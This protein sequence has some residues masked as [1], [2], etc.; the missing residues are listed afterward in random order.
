MANE[1]LNLL[2][3]S[4]RI[5][6]SGNTAVIAEVLNKI[7]PMIESGPWVEANDTWAHRMTKRF[8][9]PTPSWRALNAGV[10]RTA[11]KSTQVTEPIGILEDY[12]EA[13][14]DLI[15]TSPDPAAQ[16]WLE[17]KA[18]IEGM[19]Q[20]L[21]STFL[22]GNHGSDPEEFNGLA[23]RLDST[24][25]D[26][27]VSAGGTGSTLTSVYVVQW[28][29]DRVHWLYPRNNKTA[30]IEHKDM[31]EVTILD[32][33]DSTKQFQAYRDH[34]KVNA[35]LA[36]HDDRCIARL[37]NIT[38]ASTGSDFDEDDLIEL[39]DNMP[40]EGEGCEVYVPQYVMTRMRIQVKD[41]A[42]YLL[43]F[44]EAMGGRKV[45]TFGGH[46][47]RK[48]EAILKTETAIS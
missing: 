1:Y 10:A 8:S 18:H 36:V 30:G 47:V 37:C 7:N 29:P 15:N 26:N 17:A 39:I 45:L 24:S 13:D 4:R 5:D 6:P 40:Y 48:V 31:G 27:V 22:Y 19:A 28:G 33:N 21:A 12:S 38:T 16:R 11:S 14:V 32:P 35:G 46:P 20:E 2:E 25:Q 44:E 34:Y 3:L 42:N 23:V 9:L 41:K 43:N